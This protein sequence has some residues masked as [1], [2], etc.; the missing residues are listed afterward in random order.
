MA[1]EIHKPHLMFRSRTNT[2]T[3]KQTHEHISDPDEDMK[4]STTGLT[5]FSFF[6]KRV[7]GHVDYNVR[8]HQYRYLNFAKVLFFYEWKSLPNLCTYEG[9]ADFP[10]L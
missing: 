4:K 9:V 6:S 2:H 7:A 8:R 3:S 10:F 1:P 5:L